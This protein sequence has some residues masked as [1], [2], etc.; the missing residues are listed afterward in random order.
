M[1]DTWTV[2][3]LKQGDLALEILPGIGGRLWDV[4][5]HGKSLLFQN[6]DLVGRTVDLSALDDLPTHSPQFG[7][8]LWGGEKTWVAPD[9]EWIE[10]AP[11]PVLDS[12][13]YRVVWT[14][15]NQIDMQSDICPLSQLR[16]KRLIELEGPAAFSINHVLTNEGDTDRIAG[17][18]SVMMLPHPTTVEIADATGS[19]TPVFGD[20]RAFVRR[21]GTRLSVR[22]DESVEFK[23]GTD[24]PA[25]NIELSIGPPNARF[26]LECTVP[27]IRSGES[28]AH[29]HNIE[30]FNSGDYSYCEAE[31]HSPSQRLRPG[32]E[33]TFTQRFEIS[34]DHPAAI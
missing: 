8:P 18:W 22:C 33:I 26:C 31:W 10:G 17:I 25:G 27:A 6:P 12:A 15:D 1:D 14:T 3:S 9:T 2:L 34:T 4:V 5:F 24:A 32:G 11:Y 20:H 21:E 30:V 16:V 7:F 19:I 23:F 28:Y 29:G 13:P